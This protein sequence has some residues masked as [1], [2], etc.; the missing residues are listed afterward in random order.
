MRDEAPLPAA[1][2][3]LAYHGGNLAADSRLLP[4][5]PAPRIDLS[6][7]VSPHSFPLPEISSALRARLPEPGRLAILEAA[8]ARRYGALSSQVVAAPAA[9]ALIQLLARLRRNARIGVLGG[10]ILVRP[11]AELPDRLSFGIPDD[12][13]RW[14]RLESTLQ[15][16]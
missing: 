6:T 9:Q 15:A 7:G 14:R 10:G 1:F 13:Q 2:G 4:E 12:A 11:S 8:A 3:E 16:I 5:A